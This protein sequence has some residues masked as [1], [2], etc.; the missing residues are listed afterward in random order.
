MITFTFSGFGCQPA[1]PLIV[2]QSTS[3]PSMHAKFPETTWPIW[4][5]IAF[6]TL[7][8]V[9]ACRLSRWCYWLAVPVALVSV[10]NGWGTLIHNASFRNAMIQQLGYPYVLQYASTF[11]LPVVA[12]TLYAAY[13]FS[14]RRKRTAEPASRDEP[15]PS[16]SI[17]SDTT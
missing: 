3:T 6:I 4:L 2:R 16:A 5:S 11:A 1:G 12:I 10:Y 15:P 13:D 17:G 8:S 7:V 14:Y 9:C